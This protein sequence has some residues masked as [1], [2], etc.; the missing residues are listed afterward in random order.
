MALDAIQSAVS[1][2]SLQL[3][4]DNTEKADYLLQIAEDSFPHQEKII[5][6]N[7]LESF[8]EGAN[9]LKEWIEKL[10]QQLEDKKR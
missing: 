8:K 9:K 7:N 3:F 5:E 4:Y 1:Q 6:E 10:R 2:A